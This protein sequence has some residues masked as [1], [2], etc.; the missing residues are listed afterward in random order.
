MTRKPPALFRKPVREN[1]FEKR[2][3]RYLEQPADRKF[4]A[5][6]FTLRDGTY[7][8]TGEVTAETAK[9]LA[10]LAKAIRANRK[11]P[12]RMLPFAA[13][14]A[15]LAGLFV[16]FT[17]FL[18]PMLENALER[19]LET[20]FQARV[21]I[22]RFR[23]SLIRFTVGLEH[24]TIADRDEPMRN[25]IEMGRTGITLNPRAVLRGKIYIEEIRADALRFGT[26]R[27]VSG[28]LPAHRAKAKTAPPERE[29]PPVIDL[30][31]FD[32]G[33]LLNRELGKLRSPALYDEAA[34]FY[35]ATIAAWNTRAEEGRRRLVE[36]EAAAR[37]FITF[38]VNSINVRD[39]A[40]L[41][42]A[43]QLAADARNAVETLRAAVDTANG[44]AAGL[45]ADIDAARLLEAHARSAVEADFARL[46]SYIDLQGGAAY[47]EI[48]EPLIGDLLTAQG[49]EYIRYGE[50]ALE[51]LE[52][53]RALG[54]R[55]PKTQ[56]PAAPAFR[57]RTVTF[58]SRAYPF[59]YLR[60]LAS[61]FTLNGWNW[62]FELGDISSDPDMTGK[63]ARLHFSLAET[64]GPRRNAALAASADFRRTAPERFGVTVTGA[65]FPVTVTDPL[66]AI[67]IG[68][69]RGNMA[70]SLESRGGT[71]G[72][73]TLGGSV[74]LRD[75][76]IEDARGTIAGA[77][78]GAAAE[79]D[80]ITLGIGFSHS[81]SGANSL[82]VTAN[83]V[84][85]IMNALERAARLYAAKAI[86]ELERTLRG[87]IDSY[88]NGLIP[89]ED[90]D[91][92]F[93]LARGDAAALTRLQGSLQARI[94]EIEGKIR[95]AADEAVDEAKRR[96]DAAEAETRR[97]AA[98]AEEEARRR[99]EDARNQAEAE[100]RRRAAEAEAEVRR[101]AEEA[102][103]QAEEE[104]RRRA[105]DAV[106]GRLGF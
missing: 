29:L 88:T 71:G 14:A 78:A 77:I 94:D 9:K 31:R 60:T 64:E 32:A 53:V 54:A 36:I 104:A 20:V 8:F 24:I 23:L 22:D 87:Y 33:A 84:S 35:A 70:F 89:R 10:A 98:E 21:T 83:I 58:P 85:L 97:R 76:A 74:D 43:R 11:F 103:R 47:R 63:P 40:S 105:G 95:G 61:D 39:P 6:C 17:V 2:L 25:L 93:A 5:S 79:T 100:A 90:L 56:K 7:T 46:K 69:F 27:T 4:L 1:L 44:V 28:A 55:L 101:Q 68:A 45:G 102:R 96:L 106:R 62:A 41:E 57:G 38:N 34:S 37:P 13:L 59:F 73:F 99:A 52:Q 65:N 12:V 30:A 51:A 48:I 92:L 86:A 75:P 42:R 3:L 19:G 50:R 18:N 91:N 80:A 67:G 81:A 66:P 49:R 26:P 72:A 16:F 82:T 15:A